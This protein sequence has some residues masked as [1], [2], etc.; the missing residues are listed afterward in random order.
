MQTLAQEGDAYAFGVMLYELY[1][2]KP[3]WANLSTGEIISAKLRSHASV[4]LQLVPDAPPALQVLVCLPLAVSVHLL[5][6]SSCCMCPVSESA[7]CPVWLKQY[8]TAQTAITISN[9]N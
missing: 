4:S 3:A 1:C 5:L 8:I 7:M 6:C 9:D 2:S